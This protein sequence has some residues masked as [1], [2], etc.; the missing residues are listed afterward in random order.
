MTVGQVKVVGYTHLSVLF[1]DIVRDSIYLATDDH[2]VWLSSINFGHI[3][4]DLS[5]MSSIGERV[6]SLPCLGRPF[7]LGMLY[8][9][10]TD[11]IIPGV[12]YWDSKDLRGTE[13]SMQ[14]YQPSSSFELIAEDSIASKTFHLDVEANLALSFMSGMV[15]VSGSAKYLTDRKESKKTSRV[16]LQF[17]CTSHFRELPMEQLGHMNE[18]YIAKVDNDIATHVV[19]GV[20]Y[21]ADAFFVFDRDIEGKEDYQ[22]VHGAMQIAIKSIPNIQIEGDGKVKI[23]SKTKEKTDKFHCKF[24]GDI[25]LPENPT[26]FEGAVK[27]YQDL[28][29]LIG[30]TEKKNLSS[31]SKRKEEGEETATGGL[32]LEET[33][34]VTEET[35][36]P[37]TKKDSPTA[38][39]SISSM[40]KNLKTV[41]KTV[42]LYP[43]AKLQ[44]ESKAK[45]IVREISSR[46]VGDS[47]KLLE[48]LHDV[49]MRTNDLMKTNTFH[50][51]QGI[52]QQLMHF[53]DLVTHYETYLMQQLSVILP[54]IRGGGMEEQELADLFMNN[55]D[56]PFSYFRLVSYLDRKEREIKVLEKCL[57]FMGKEEKPAKD[58]KVGKSLEAPD[59]ET[60]DVAKPSA[61]SKEQ[62]AE[63]KKSCIE[64][65]FRTGEMDSVIYSFDHEHV[66]SFEFA[67]IERKDKFLEDMQVYLKN[68]KKVIGLALERQ[69]SRE[70]TLEKG[71]YEDS[72]LIADMRNKV[73]HFKRF[74]RANTHSKKTCF[75]ITDGSLKPNPPVPAAGDDD[76]LTASDGI[77]K[78]ALICLYKG[79]MPEDYMPPCQPGIPRDIA[80]TSTSI[81]LKWEEPKYGKKAVDHYI[82]SYC[83]FN[84]ESAPK[85]ADEWKSIES[86]TNSVVIKQ[87]ERKQ[88]YKFRVKSVCSIGESE[89]SDTSQVIETKSSD[90]LQYLIDRST[91]ISPE[92]YAFCSENTNLDEKSKIAKSE[93]GKFKNS[94]KLFKTIVVTGL[95]ASAR[96]NMIDALFNYVYGI[97]WRDNARFRL[98]INKKEISFENQVDWAKIF[99]IVN[100]DGMEIRI[101][102]TLRIVEIPISGVR[103]EISYQQIISVFRDNQISCINSVVYAHTTCDAVSDSVL[104]I[105]ISHLFSMY[106]RELK[107]SICVISSGELKRN[108]KDVFSK[109]YSV[110]KTRMFAIPFNEYMNPFLVPLEKVNDVSK[111]FE[112]GIKLFFDHLDSASDLP[113]ISLDETLKLLNHE[114]LLCKAVVELHSTKM[115][116]A[117]LTMKTTFGQ[118]RLQMSIRQYSD[119]VKEN[120]LVPNPTHSTA[121]MD[122]YIKE[123]GPLT[124]EYLCFK[125]VLAILIGEANGIGCF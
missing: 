61:E 63:G 121:V 110:S 33:D 5:A 102:F 13:E 16:T 62:S 86:T 9:C 25:L 104:K 116:Q 96:R 84:P 56:S 50:T 74:V 38:P 32:W 112:E 120:C 91:L 90:H 108:I 41:P 45:T 24:Y 29:V 107:E 37:V 87:L 109:V 111:A 4:S 12:T 14:S 101:P 75:A 22:E 30:I 65:A 11:S 60:S 26:T 67:N 76:S 64:F 42:W 18:D 52:K 28:P 73:V 43:L 72:S 2:K 79:G 51:F 66:L 125:K 19:T 113:D 119:T 53:K 94:S 15:S 124:S 57:E 88:G 1:R 98:S 117:Q 83:P 34:S 70:T 20:V 54:Q 21:G 122:V 123:I 17:T 95:S 39:S 31:E 59:S 3:H 47:E 7:R 71:W 82:V 58:D 97:A 27:V 115:A 55:H 49:K 80:K 89:E 92:T 100:E 23:E 105:D 46:L 114:Q 40:L 10:R 81:K 36:S 93:I 35:D 118:S 78:G 106:S 6:L 85:E 69:E 48:S 44:K 99:V 68:P 77:K 103:R 8:D